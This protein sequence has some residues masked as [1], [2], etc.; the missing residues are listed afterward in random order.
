VSA[1]ASRP[2]VL[3]TRPLGPAI[4]AT[5]AE[6]FELRVSPA[7]HAEVI[8]RAL[9]AFDPHAVI[10]RDDL[11]AETCV[12]APSLLHLARHGV[13]LDVIPM[14]ACAQHGVTVS[15]V[16]GGNATSVAE[17]CVA[18][19]LALLHS[20]PQIGA[21]MRS[22]G[23]TATRAAFSG[24][25][26]DLAGRQVGLIGCGAIGSAL[27]TMLHAGLGA[28]VSAHTRSPSRLPAFVV[29]QDFAQCVAQADVLV[30]CV[31]LTDQTRGLIS[32]EAI[33]TMKPGAL[34]VNASRGEVVDEAALIAA[35]RSGQLG[36]AALDVI[37]DRQGRQGTGLPDLPNLVV[38]PHLAG[39]TAD[40]AERNGRSVI[41]ALE[42]VLLGGQRPRHLVNESAWAP[43]L[44]RRG[45]LLGQT[46]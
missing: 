15:N 37:I 13:G 27:A 28:R 17:W 31:P 30:P 19:I 21:S 26:H 40:A 24:R 38:T 29:A 25:A 41:E 22:Q 8:A 39:H 14:A 1:P 16:P 46:G 9:A 34:F 35:L 45:R 33:A 3:S 20:L 43:M 11:P 42:A 6:R 18:Q 10:V 7:P 4:A 44:A 32:A 5:L 2:R 36:G 12:L 23:W